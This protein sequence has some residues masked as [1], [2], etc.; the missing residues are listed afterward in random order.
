MENSV[1]AG[2]R[3]NPVIS[4]TNGVVDHAAVPMHGPVNP[5]PAPASVD[6]GAA[7]AVVARIARQAHQ[8]VDKVAEAA[9]PTAQWL[10]AKSENLASSGR[11]AVADARVYVMANP[12][13]SLGVAA[14]AGFLLGRL[15]R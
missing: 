5:M 7:P 3:F 1:I 15:A 8:T 2:Q 11:S 9:T 10:S 6:G 4:Q 12:W 13:Q 14:A